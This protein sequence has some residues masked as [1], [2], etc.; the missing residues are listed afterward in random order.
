M[1]KIQTKLV[2]LVYSLPALE[3][4]ISYKKIGYPDLIMYLQYDVPL[5]ESCELFGKLK[6]SLCKKDYSDLRYSFEER[7]A[8]LKTILNGIESCVDKWNTN[9]SQANMVYGEAIEIAQ[10][11]CERLDELKTFPSF[12]VHYFPEKAAT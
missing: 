3:I 7:K 10:Q 9:G 5:E 2:E 8:S 6:Q 11:I 4:C 1:D 12:N